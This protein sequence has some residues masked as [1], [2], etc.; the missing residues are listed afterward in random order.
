M[1]PGSYPVDAQLKD[2]Q[3]LQQTVVVSESNRLVDL[4]LVPVPAPPPAVGVQTGTLVVRAG[5]P[6]ALVYIDGT[7]QSSRTDQSGSATFQLEA[8]AHEVR[9][10]RNDYEKARR[11]SRSRSGLRASKACCST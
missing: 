2:Y 4:R 7:P 3:P 11:R 5:V 6:D 1:A 8:K 9:V 10:E